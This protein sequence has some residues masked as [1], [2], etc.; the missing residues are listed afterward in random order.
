MATKSKLLQPRRTARFRVNLPDWADAILEAG[1]VSTD[2]HTRRRQR[3][4]NIA[5]YA[6]GLNAF[7][8]LLVNAVYDFQALLP[9]NIYNLFA[10]IF[11]LLLPQLHRY[12][13]NLVA[14]LLIVFSLIGHSYIV[15]AFG[16]DSNLHVYFTLAGVILFFVGLKHW[17]NFLILYVMSIAALVIAM[18]FASRQGFV[19]SGDVE[20]RS[21]LALQAMLSAI[22][23]N[24]VVIAFV[25]SALGHAE[26]NLQKEYDRSELLLTTILPPFIA[27]RLK[28]GEEQT[29]ADK[30]DAA[31]VLFMDLAGFT[32]AALH[33]S[34]EEVVDYLHRLFSRL[35]LLCEQMCV[36]KIK[37]IGDSYMAVGGL[38]D[39]AEIGFAGVRNIGRLAIAMRGIVASEPLAGKILAMRAGIHVGPV[40]AGVIG[41]RRI[42]YDVWGDTVN[43]ASRLESSS[44]IGH[45]HVSDAFRLAA[46]NAFVFE[47]RG[48]V[49]LK[50]IG[51]HQTYFL[52]S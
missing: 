27:D 24:A 44:E 33:A 41:D 39:D 42:A 20:F 25:L 1:I 7:I 26:E 51:M 5:A 13:E 6:L 37:T 35:D 48:T 32:P 23:L 14:N 28:S 40:I 31:S 16:L 45:I 47:P 49:G 3:F 34:P 18:M 36:D 43:F 22:V 17:R 46:E 8:H 30:Y 9:I 52:H 29:I 21:R 19:L 4:T 50:G 38:R 10:C 15:F 2:A 12:G 11:Y